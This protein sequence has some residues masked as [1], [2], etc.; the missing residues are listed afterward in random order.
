MQQMHSNMWKENPTTIER[1]SEPGVPSY[2]IELKAKKS[3]GRLRL[4]VR[5]N[6]ETMT[7]LT[8]VQIAKIGIIA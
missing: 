3:R 1:D 5:K 2:S 7:A 8:T 4:S 6:C